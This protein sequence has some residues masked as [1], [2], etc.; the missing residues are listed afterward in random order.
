MKFI[1]RQYLLRQFIN[2]NKDILNV[3]YVEKVQGKG[4]SSNDFTDE[5]KQKL[6]LLENYDDTELRNKLDLLAEGKVDKVEG[7]GLSANDFTNEEKLKLNRLENYNDEEIR[8]KVTSLYSEI[9]NILHELGIIKENEFFSISCENRSIKITLKNGT[10]SDTDISGIFSE[11]SIEELKNVSGKGKQD[12]YSLAYDEILDIWKPVKIDLEGT[13]NKANEYSDSLS[14]Q[15]KAYADNVLKN[16]KSYTDG[17][18]SEKI[19]EVIA[20]AP[21]DLDTL[22]EIADWIS[23][24]AESASAMNSQINTNKSDISALKTSVAGKAEAEHT[25]DDKYYTESEV[26]TKLSNKVDKVN[27]K[28]LSTNDYTTTEKNKLAG[29]NNYDDTEVRGLIKDEITRATTAENNLSTSINNVKSSAVTSV[30]YDS[31]NKKITKTINETT[32][33]VVTLATMKDAMALNNVT[34][35][36]TE[37][38]ITKDSTKNITSGAVYTLKQTVDGNKSAIDTLNGTGIGSVK[39]TV[40]DEIA[41][42]VANAPSDFDTLKEISD[43]IDTHEDSASAMNTQINTNKS[44]IADLKTSVAGKSNTGHTHTKSE[45]T[46]LVKSLSSEDLNDFKSFGFYYSAGGNSVVNKPSGTDAF[47]M[48][49]IRTAGGW[50]TQ[51]MYATDYGIYIRWW[52]GSSWTKW[53]T[54]INSQLSLTSDEI[55]SIFG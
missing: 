2:F 50:Y 31:T 19:A 52:N 5:E 41:K 11:T 49:V 45:I 44:D 7:K 24:H 15:D 12:G 28:G 34:N 40:T 23:T 54:E 47:G 26:D 39:K 55:D 16:A 14:L 21:E 13:L 17:T 8:N 51:V 9:E 48:I 33:D 10:Y 27:G 36:A 53:E 6:F 37:S 29:L 38:T 25:H 18:V 32:S 20:N 3:L 1:D 35:V 43:W 30:D 4:L 42:I 46:D 22:K